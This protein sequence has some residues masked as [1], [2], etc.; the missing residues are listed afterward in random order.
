M[1]KRFKLSVKR[2]HLSGCPWKMAA[3]Y[4]HVASESLHGSSRLTLALDA[5]RTGN[6]MRMLAFATS[7]E[8]GFWSPPLVALTRI[9]RMR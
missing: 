4:L 2:K 9:P 5:A 3:R 1:A 6:R 8:S 7:G